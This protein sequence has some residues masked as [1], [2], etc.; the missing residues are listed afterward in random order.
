MTGQIRQQ[1]YHWEFTEKITYTT[2]LVDSMTEL[3]SN[4]VDNLDLD[5]LVKKLHNNS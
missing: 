3:F 1:K 2:W 4:F 5:G